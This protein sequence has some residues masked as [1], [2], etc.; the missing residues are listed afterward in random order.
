MNYD[1]AAY[2]QTN[3]SAVWK[4]DTTDWSEREKL[5]KTQTA[6]KQILAVFSAIIIVLSRYTST[7]A[8]MII[9]SIKKNKRFFLCSI[10]FAPFSSYKKKTHTHVEVREMRILCRAIKIWTWCLWMT[11]NKKSYITIHVPFS[12]M[13]I[14]SRVESKRWNANLP[15]S[16]SL[17]YMCTA[18]QIHL[19]NI[20]I[21]TCLVLTMMV[22]MT[23]PLCLNLQF[24]IRGMLKRSLRYTWIVFIWAHLRH[25]RLSHCLYLCNITLLFG[26]YH[27]TYNLVFEYCYYWNMNICFTPF[28]TSSNFEISRAMI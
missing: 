19:H 10:Q 6:F 27:N 13:S 24:S 26:E 21:L 28:G 3:K 12:L 25:K 16:Y 14:P 4:Y 20:L 23:M 5:T 1:S 9:K 18:L 15:F 11:Q 2:A 17:I 8:C 22:M 7:R